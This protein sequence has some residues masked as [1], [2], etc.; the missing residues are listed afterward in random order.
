MTYC[1]INNH[2][3]PTENALISVEDRGFRYGDGVFETIAV[4]KGVPYQFDWHM[5]RLIGGLGAIKIAFD[6]SS[7]KD[8]CRQLVAKNGVKS[9]ILRIQVTRG[10]GSRGYLP[11][12]AHPKADASFV[13][14]TSPMPA[15][16]REPVAL[17]QSHYQKISARALPV[18]YKLCQGLNSTLARLEAAE[19]HCA[20]ALLINEHEQLCETSSGNIFWLKN[21]KLYT[22]SLDCGVLAGSTR[23]A[24]LR[25]SPCPVVET[26]AGID[27]LAGAEAVFITN[28]VW[29]ALA[30]G[31]LFPQNIKWN[32]AGIAGKFHGLILADRDTYSDEQSGEWKK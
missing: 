28:V 8:L 21:E 2:L 16:S 17:W 24:L 7:I 15:I 25:L 30:V 20:D 29:G 23:A 1:I 14:E 3:V 22:P 18:Q 4:H 32:S 13:I 31:A 19:N 26:D 10:I 9:G 6:V 5:A 27:A 12:P 11:D